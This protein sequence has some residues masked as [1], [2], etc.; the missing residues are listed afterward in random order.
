MRNILLICAD[1]MRYDALAALGNPIA[2]TPHLDSIATAG[3]RFR[4]HMTP[5]QI[6][7]PS[8]ASLFTGL[9]PRHHGLHRNGVAL[10]QDVPTLPGQLQQ[11]GFATHA[12][13]KLHLQPIKAPEALMMPE[14]DAFWQ[15]GHGE[16]WRGPYFGF[17]T[18]DLVIGEADVCTDGGHYA[19]WLKQH[20]PEAVPLYQPEQ[21]LMPVPEDLD[22]IWQAAIPQQL[23]YNHWIADRAIDFI[24]QQSSEQPFFLYVSFPDPHHPFSPPAPY[25]DH[26]DP[27]EMPVP[28]AVPGELEAMPSYYLEQRHPREQ[29]FMISTDQISDTTLQQAIAHTYGMIEMIDDQVGRMLESLQQAGLKQDT[30]VIFTSDHGEFLGDHGLL[31]KGPPPYRQILQT[32]MIMQGPGL[33]QDVDIDTLSSHMDIPNTLLDYVG[34]APLEGDGQS[35]LPLMTSGQSPSRQALFA[36]YHTRAEDQLYNHSIITQQWRLTL[37]PLEPSWG[38]LFDRRQDPDETRNLYY[39]E[40]YA[41]IVA[42]LSEQLATQLPAQPEVDSAIL[43]IY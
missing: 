6:C 5:C 10:E 13:G 12:V 27:A 1:Q 22:E 25:C 31:R 36:E 35:L 3:L 2:K 18:V 30:L 41:D 7:S 40:E 38:E 34:V 16:Q 42:S 19:A 4:Q 29:G 9:Y 23:H 28:R 32:P 20:H 26:F 11:A 37:Y 24:D 21:S 33:P 39:L 8:R 17:D 43:A 15:A 14:S